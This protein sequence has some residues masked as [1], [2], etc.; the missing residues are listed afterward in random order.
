MEI[1]TVSAPTVEEASNLVMIICTPSG[2][3]VFKT[4][5]TTLLF[6]AD[7]AI[8]NKFQSFMCQAGVTIT[9]P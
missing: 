3:F 4:S 1:F 5:P 9:I 8:C 6:K 7:V 2:A